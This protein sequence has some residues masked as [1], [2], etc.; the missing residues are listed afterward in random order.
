MNIYVAHSKNIE[1]INELYTPIKSSEK[2]KDYT[3]HFPHENDIHNFNDHN[4]Y[5]QF[6]LIIAEVSQASTGLGIELGFASVLNVPII[7]IFKTNSK[8]GNSL[9]SIT[10]NFIQY[11]DDKDMINKIYDYLKN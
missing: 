3:F 10:S 4:Y 11:A 8:V 6:D 2:L 1:Y 5:K 9:K 7:C